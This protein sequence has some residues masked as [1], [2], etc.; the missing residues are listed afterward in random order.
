MEENV[1]RSEL[2][3][4]V[5]F[6]PALHGAWFHRH[7]EIADSP[8]VLVAVKLVFRNQEIGPQKGALEDAAVGPRGQELDRVHKDDMA[9]V[10]PRTSLDDRVVGLGPE[11]AA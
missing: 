3:L 4:D 6:S 11:H 9:L 8:L 7:L 2:P 10:L 5:T 1:P